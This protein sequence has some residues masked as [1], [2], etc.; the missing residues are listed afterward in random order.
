MSTVR[1]LINELKSGGLPLEQV[2]KEL[3]AG[4]WPLPAK[5]AKTV[6]QAYER[7]EEIPGDNDVFWI[8]EA[9]LNRAISEDDYKQLIE[10]MRTSW[11]IYA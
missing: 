4:D 10:A 11:H 8:R 2:V 6:L 9:Y 1:Q 7:A 3:S 5:A